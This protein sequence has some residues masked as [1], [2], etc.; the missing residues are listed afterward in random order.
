MSGLH[1]PG[2]NENSRKKTVQGLQGWKNKK[3][4]A[5]WEWVRQEANFIVCRRKADFK[6][7]CLPGDWDILPESFNKHAH[8]RVSAVSTVAGVKQRNICYVQ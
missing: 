6:L 2:K 5:L 4:K 3:K 8:W 1:N 7:K